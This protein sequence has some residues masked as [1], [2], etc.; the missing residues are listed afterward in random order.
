VQAFYLA[1]LGSARVLRMDHQIGNLAPGFEAD[2]VVLDPRAK[3]V[4]AERVGVAR[5]IEDVLF[6]LMILGD[7]RVVKAVFTQGEQRV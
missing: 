5:S 1:S 4:L 7:D 6:A 3:P 2:I